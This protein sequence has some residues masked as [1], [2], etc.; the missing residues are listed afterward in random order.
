MKLELV[1]TAEPIMRE[2]K[3]V[4]EMEFGRFGASLNIIYLSNVKIV[5]YICV[6]G[7]AAIVDVGLFVIFAE[8]M[9]FNYF[10]VGAVS[11]IL[12]TFVNYLL[13]IRYVFKSGTRFERRNEIALIF[14][15]SGIGLLIN[16]FVLF[17]GVGYFDFGKTASKLIASATVFF[18]N[19]SL[20]ANFVF[21]K[22]L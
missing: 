17:C 16:Q 8:V 14:F 10:I 13:S 11:F 18:W 15:I 22:D 6:G 7:V 9:E 2:R 5:K 21:K 3:L 12:A 4:G 1:I 20:R 19:Y